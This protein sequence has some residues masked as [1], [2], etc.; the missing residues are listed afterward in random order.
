MTWVGQEY[1]MHD[2]VGFVYKIT[3]ISDGKFYI[4]CKKLSQKVVRK[5]LKGKTRKRHSIKESNWQHYWGSCKELQDDVQKLGEDKFTREI[6]QFAKSQLMLKYF[7]LKEQL[8]NDIMNPYVNTYNGIINVRLPR[9]SKKIWEQEFEI[10]A[11]Y[12]KDLFTH[13]KIVY[14]TKVEHPKAIVKITDV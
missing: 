7:E 1:R 6:I 13:L 5:P 4:G 9:P 12:E 11:H 8:D 2:D 3:R 14:D 10:G